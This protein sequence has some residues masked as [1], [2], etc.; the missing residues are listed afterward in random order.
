MH[1]EVWRSLPDMFFRQAEHRSGQPFLWSKRDG[2]FQPI[3]YGEAAQQVK[4]FARGLRDLGIRPGDRV[5]LISENRPE[6]LV[7]DMA[8]MTAGAITVPTFTTNTTADHQYILAHSGARAAIV[9]TRTIA[10]TLLPAAIEAPELEFVVS[11]EDLGLAQQ[12]TAPVVSW[13]EVMDRGEARPDDSAEMM[14]ELRRDAVC[15]FIYT[16]GTGGTPKGVMLTHGSILANCMGAYHLLVDYFGVHKE[17]FLSFL[18]LSHAYEHTAGQFFPISIGAE[19]Y[20]AESVEK[21]TD[22]MATVRPTIMTA[23]PRLYEVMHHRIMRTVDKTEGLQ[24][25]LFLLAHELG[26]QKYERPGSLTLWQRI[27]DLVAELLVRRKVRRR[28]GGRLKALV[29]GGAALSYDIGLFFTAL[30]VR[31]LQGYGQTEA[32]PV[33]SANP[34]GRIKLRTVGPPVKG[35][36]LRIA[37]DGE[38]LVRGELVMK[39]YWRD[40]QATAA[41][42]RDGWLHT[43][44]IGEIDDEGYLKITDRKKDII[45]L[46]GGDNVAPARIEG[47]LV[48]QPE[49]NQAMVHGDKRPHL[50]AL[51]VPE[52][53]FILDWARANGKSADLAALATDGDF[54]RALGGAVDRVN[55]RLSRIEKIRRFAIVP[56]PFTIENEMMTPSLKIRRH[57]IRAAHG[58]M[59]EKLYE[60]ATG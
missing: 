3:T 58:Q 12:P 13:A 10:K 4:L 42:I 50:V 59:M 46:S 37:E 27:L 45:V 55:A 38:V 15:C 11:M 41:V 17:V 14:A 52:R 20:Y 5:A 49:I 47:F 21:L 2:V 56:E 44:D 16:S 48:L 39:G 57:K 23:V 35:A 24:K 6:W 9:S 26:R 22:D 32:S 60:K 1:Y 36:E 51:L 19:I 7:A 29:S 33:V 8:I 54:H 25:K 31:I 30:G 40:A 28:F 34:P 43:G 53:D 18:P